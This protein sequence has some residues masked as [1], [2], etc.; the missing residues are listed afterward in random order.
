MTTCSDETEKTIDEITSLSA[1][2]RID[3]E[4]V[5]KILA[6]NGVVG[7]GQAEG[8]NEGCCCNM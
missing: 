8:E 1:L 5:R 7:I 3:L 4:D 6:N 2:V